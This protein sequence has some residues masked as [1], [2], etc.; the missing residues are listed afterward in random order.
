MAIY[1]RKNKKGENRYTVVP[2]YSGP[3]GKRIRKGCK[4]FA[5]EKEAKKYETEMKYK[6]QNNLI[7]APS[8]VSF[9]QMADIWLEAIKVNVAP[10]TF[11]GYKRIVVK[12]LIPFMGKMKIQA[13]KRPF[14]KKYFASLAENEQIRA[15]RTFEQHRTVLIGIFSEAI[16]NGFIMINPAIGL[17]IP[18]AAKKAPPMMLYERKVLIDFINAIDGHP[19]LP[20]VIL[21]LYYGLRRGEACGLRW[22][23]IDWDKGVISINRQRI[24]VNGKVIEVDLKTDNSVRRLSLTEKSKQILMAEYARQQENKK[25]LGPEYKDTGYI[26]VRNDG[27]PYHPTSRSNAMRDLWLSKGFPPMV[28]H[29]LRHTF[30]RINHKAGMDDYEL[31]KALG[32]GELRTTHEYIEKLEEAEY[33]A[34]SLVDSWLE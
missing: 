32:H 16:D 10:S 12:Y 19:M 2:E 29:N 28:L 13:T 25:N 14:L 6:M 31:M 17:K 22:E 8:N 1:C 3:N 5:S 20:M 27:Q 9:E 30:A 15:R 24:P 21:C 26:I 7:S 23:D 4:T 34:T 18:K 33:V 11:D